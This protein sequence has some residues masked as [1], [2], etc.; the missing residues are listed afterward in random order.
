MVT[1][2]AEPCTFGGVTLTIGASIGIARFPNDGDAV[3]LLVR[4]A[5]RAMYEAKQA[6]RR[7]MLFSECPPA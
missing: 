2:L 3:D 7:V 4:R 1:R 5:D 6:G